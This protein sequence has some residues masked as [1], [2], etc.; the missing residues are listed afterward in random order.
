MDKKQ[1]MDFGRIINDG[2]QDALKSGDFAKLN[3][4]LNDTVESVVEKTIGGV[5]ATGKAAS[6]MLGK[7]WGKPPVGW[8]PGAWNPGRVW[9]APDAREAPSE[10][11]DETAKGQSAQNAPSSAAP[12]ADAASGAPPKQSAYDSYAAQEVR[13]AQQRRTTPPPPPRKSNAPSSPSARRQQAAPQKQSTKPAVPPYFKR[14]GWDVFLGGFMAVFG[15]LGAIPVWTSAVVLVLDSSVWST[16]LWPIVGVA[17]LV[18]AAGLLTLCAVSGLRRIGRAR[19]FRCYWNLLKEKGFCEVSELALGIGKSERFVVKDLTRLLAGGFFPQGK[20]DQNK[21]CLI[22][23][24]ELYRQYR[25]TMENQQRIA[26][27]EKPMNPVVSAGLDAVRQIRAANEALPDEVVSEKLTRLEDV[28]TGIF[29]YVQ[30]HPDKLPE[31]RRFMD[32]YLPT[33]LKLVRT[34]QDFEEQADTP[35]IAA[36]QTEILATLDTISQAFETLLDGL[37]QDDTMDISSDISVLKTMLA[38]EG[39][40]ENEFKKG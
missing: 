33:T 11:Q 10:P 27:P 16:S 34:Y 5:A 1:G 18:G 28:T 17:A 9:E 21:S 24:E 26:E 23:G 30:Q 32:Y 40:T 20:F 8:G 6:K 22:W 13:R 2:L 19:R 36:A 3:N 12:G 15:F 4:L 31:I 38:Q 14:T 39:L 25:L 35:S 37:Y 7:D 29:A